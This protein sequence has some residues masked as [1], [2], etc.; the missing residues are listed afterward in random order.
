MVGRPMAGRFMARTILVA[1]LLMTLAVPVV[2]SAARG[3]QAHR[4][5]A[6]KSASTVV[7]EAHNRASLLR[8]Q[9]FMFNWQTVTQ[10]RRDLAT[11]PSRAPDIVKAIKAQGRT[12]GAT[13][14]VLVLLLIIAIG[15]GLFGRKRFDTWAEKELA[16]LGER[17]PKEARPW[18]SAAVHVAAA[19]LI[20]LVLWALYQC[21]AE[22]TEYS[23]PWFL[24]LGTFLVAWTIYS[25]AVRAA[26]EL[27]VRPLLR[28]PPEHGRYLFRVGRWVLVYGIGISVILDAALRLGVPRDIITLGQWLLQFTLIVLLALVFAHRRA[29]MSLFPDLP[30]HLYQRFIRALDRFYPVVFIVTL[31][32]A[33]IEWAGFQTLADFIWIRTWAVIGIIVGAA[34]LHNLLRR[35]LRQLIIGSGPELERA[36]NFYRS[37]G[38]LLDY[39]GF[40]AVFVVVLH[41][42]G[43][44]HP[45]LHFLN[46]PLAKLG[47]QMLSF[48]VILE[49]GVIVAAFMFAATLMRDYLEFQVYPH[50]HVD[51][52]VAHAINTFLVY[53]LTAIGAIAAMEAVGLGFG[54]LTLF[55]GALGIGLGFGLQ[56][57]ANNL[58][59][60]LTLIFS[61][62]LRKGD[63]VTVGDTIGVIQ[64]VGIRATR[65]RTRDDVEYM[66]PNSE[67]VSGK[68]VN[69][70]RS[71]PMTR[72]H[73][74]L[75]VSYGADP[76]RVREILESVA[77]RT[78]NVEQSPPPEVWFV[79][80]GD[81]SLNF[82]LLI[83]MNLRAVQR[84]QVASDL[85][86]ALFE[87]FK[88]AGIEIPFP[89][90][91]LHIRSVTPIQAPSLD[92]RKRDDEPDP[93]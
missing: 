4:A 21:V 76:G 62:A 52:G 49:S 73:V 36:R 17:L 5:G 29:V 48:R 14:S 45:L 63:W 81:S 40:V 58:A 19:V 54:T 56:S 90:R 44:W 46:F 59:S 66:V 18:L 82:E 20:P 11:L 85:Y 75:G 72:L 67:F 23:R 12:L 13:G 74:P 37:A 53:A 30:N 15:Y 51:P 27:L 42:T 65:M 2:A 9:H 77:A 39:L 91:D 32:T 22:L 47:T 26:Y 1:V 35:G 25:F 24:I 7:E 34:I 50:L 84:Q 31:V 28:I 43:P 3:E 38:R 55:A 88:E 10:I 93:A 89:Q 16:P 6:E 87:A 83:W 70:T 61:R 41:I 79:G 57:I 80:F 68:I 69:W 60:G 33:L 86:F 71:S 64:E 78:P 8:R 92:D